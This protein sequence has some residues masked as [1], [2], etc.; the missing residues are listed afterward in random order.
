MN[1]DKEMNKKKATEIA[2]DG[3]F[4]YGY[5]KGLINSCDANKKSIVNKSIPISVMLEMFTGAIEGKDDDEVVKTTGLN[6]Q[7]K[8]SLSV[9]GVIARNIIWELG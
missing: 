5:L 9:D 2:Y 3:G 7:W 4:T 8:T 6:H 1:K